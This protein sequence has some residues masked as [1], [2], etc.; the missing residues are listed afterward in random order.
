M[1]KILNDKK[2]TLTYSRLKEIYSDI[3]TNKT[4]FYNINENMTNVIIDI[5]GEIID[6]NDKDPPTIFD[7]ISELLYDLRDKYQEQLKTTIPIQPTYQSTLNQ[8]LDNKI[9]N[10]QHTSNRPYEDQTQ[11]II[12][13]IPI[14]VKNID[15]SK[16]KLYLDTATAIKLSNPKLTKDIINQEI[17]IL[18][19]NL[20]NVKDY[21]DI[22]KTWISIAEFNRKLEQIDTYNDLTNKLKKNLEY[23]FDYESNYEPT[24]INSIITHQQY[25]SNLQ[26][27][28]K[29]GGSTD[30]TCTNTNYNDYSISLNTC[31]YDKFSQLNI[32]LYPK[33]ISI[34]LNPEVFCEM[35][36]KSVQTS[37]P[38][39]HPYNIVNK[40]LNTFFIKSY[41]RISTKLNKTFYN[42]RETIFDRDTEL[43]KSLRIQNLMIFRDK[44]EKK[45]DFEVKVVFNYIM[46]EINKIKNDKNKYI[47]N[48]K[49]L[50]ELQTYLLQN[51][52]YI[53]KS[54]LNNYGISD[55]SFETVLEF[56]YYKDQLYKS[57]ENLKIITENFKN[58]NPFIELTSPLNIK[59]TNIIETTY[60]ELMSKF[61][62]VLT[63]VKE[64]NDGYM[65]GLKGQL[66]PRYKINLSYNKLTEASGVI[67]NEN[68]IV[69]RD[70]PIKIGDPEIKYYDFEIEY[71]NYP[72]VIGL[73]NSGDNYYTPN[74]NNKY[75]FNM[76]QSLKDIS[77][78]KSKT[79]LINNKWEKYNL[80]KINRYY[81]SEVTSEQIAED[82]ECG[83]I[84]LQKLRNFENI[85]IIG[86]GQ[87]GA[88]KTAS[89]I[90][91]TTNGVNYPGLL[92]SIANKLIK[93]TT[94]FDDKTQ[95]FE[96]AYVQLINLYLKL[97]DNLDDINKMKPEHYLPYNIKLF[98]TNVDGIPEVDSNGNKIEIDVPGYYF[99]PKDGK[100]WCVRKDDV[101]KSQTPNND[102]KENTHSKIG[103]K[104]LDQIIAE[105]FEIREEE[106]TKNNPNSSRSH[107]VV[108]VTFTGKTKNAGGN[109]V[110]KQ[111]RVVI[112]DLAGVEDKF[113]CDLSELMIL[114]RNYS[115]KSNKYKTLDENGKAF[116]QE[117]RRKLRLKP[118]QFDDYYCTDPKYNTSDIFPQKILIKKRE[119][120]DKI[121]FFMDNYD[122]LKSGKDPVKNKIAL[123]I[124]KFE[125]MPIKDKD[126]TNFMISLSDYLK[127]LSEEIKENV[128]TNVT[129][130]QYTYTKDYLGNLADT[131]NN[132]QF[133]NRDDLEL[134]L[135]FITETNKQC[136]SFK[137]CCNN[138][139]QEKTKKISQFMSDFTKLPDG[140]H[141]D[142]IHP[143][144]IKTQDYV[145]GNFESNYK[146]MNNDEVK[147]KII[148]EI[149]KIVGGDVNFFNLESTPQFNFNQ[150]DEEITSITNIYT[151]NVKGAE[152]ACN[153]ETASG[154]INE[155]N[156]QSNL[157][158]KIQDINNEIKPLED[159]LKDYNNK[160]TNKTNE[161]IKNLY[162]FKY[163]QDKNKQSHIDKSLEKIPDENTA[164][165]I[166]TYLNNEGTVL[167]AKDNKTFILTFK[168]SIKDTLKKLFV[169]NKLKELLSL[170]DLQ[171][172]IDNLQT[173]IDTN[174]DK[175]NGL[176]KFRDNLTINEIKNKLDKQSETKKN[177]TIEQAKQD[178]IV[179]LSEICKKI[180][181]EYYIN[182]I[183]YRH[184][185]GAKKIRDYLLDKTKRAKDIEKVRYLIQQLIRFSQLE[186]NCKIR[187]KEG[188]MINTS[189]KEMQK[190]IGSILFESSKRR[191]NKV[192]IE[193]NLLKLPEEIYRYNDY[194]K[195]NNEISLII[196]NLLNTMNTLIITDNPQEIERNI[197][198]LKDLCTKVK[199]KV[200]H[201]F[202]YIIGIING[203]EDNYLPQINI[204]AI[205]LHICF[206]HT[207]I[208][209][210]TNDGINFDLIKNALK[211]MGTEKYTQLY[212]EIVKNNITIQDN[213][214]YSSNATFIK[215]KN[216]FTN[217]YG[218]NNNNN[219]KDFHL[220]HAFYE[221]SEK[222]NPE[223]IN[224][225]DFMQL[226]HKL[227][228]NTFDKTNQNNNNNKYNEGLIINNELMIKSV[229]FDYLYKELVGLWKVLN[230]YTTNNIKAFE[231][232]V[233]ET[234]TDN[235]LHPSPLL[236]SSPSIDSCVL[237]K[238]KY[239]DEYDKFYNFEKNNSPLEYLF[240]IMTTSSTNS[241]IKGV[242]G[243]GLEIENST[244]VIFTVINVT[245]N[246]TA[247]TN[248]PPTPPF[249]NINKLKL[250]YKILSIPETG[251]K[252][253]LS[254]LK[255]NNKYNIISQIQ[256]I[257][258]HYYDKIMEYPFYKSFESKFSFLQN[259]DELTDNKGKRLKEDVIDF[260]DSNNATT[261][262][263]T[264]DFEKF[265]K[266]R[267]PT[268][269]YYI[270]DNKNESLLKQIVVQEK[271]NQLLTESICDLNINN[272][273]C[274]DKQHPES[275]N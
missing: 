157:D 143:D 176:I 261:L 188:Y 198:I 105:A 169:D 37:N 145:Y 138:D 217:L 115:T 75:N 123:N 12:N 195:Y 15:P 141:P 180:Q 229:S 220:L 192:L 175:I 124:Q 223:N 59:Y 130:Y 84:L 103:N 250:I 202:M 194:I 18:Y 179:N 266:I 98:N 72:H 167:S 270:C 4:I 97:D 102:D 92:P 236:Y 274:N 132:E 42:G 173:K 256:D 134:N 47:F 125:E 242:N 155:K 252:T 207:I 77:N 73:T 208:T 215:L 172:E 86:N 243:F 153:Q 139:T 11:K 199:R 35:W 275:K 61:A 265:T 162:I 189:L 36:Y 24:D 232:K 216:I 65:Y 237:K 200:L 8:T 71:F 29:V 253:V 137:D 67:S 168:K 181:I 43:F 116:S 209:L 245:P 226:I 60:I 70:K 126:N 13:Q 45:D 214:M 49:L 204:C 7:V 74:K 224:I 210:L 164:K 31:F 131:T 88:G 32:D 235:K 129:P 227:F 54:K 85:I 9:I 239:D 69:Y 104:T 154:G 136:N 222:A 161:N 225:N 6:I 244:L 218:E 28:P 19:S 203:N 58:G 184:T 170:D 119:L 201:Y 197:K 66:N 117:E 87:S 107:I 120:M 14:E 263:G 95:Y 144:D 101:V 191:F 187:R 158:K 259:I 159:E 211:N 262:L 82:A 190:F 150:Y 57:L 257:G 90:S 48:Y 78:I 264:V 89:L 51:N 113:T 205:L 25:I 254:L 247:P 149:Q 68:E 248:N 118:I 269:P 114:D 221:Y 55:T 46:K 79:D 273:N 40:L 96:T 64:R 240:K 246:P 33:L 186:F 20:S 219:K 38:I 99:M 94:K 165:T 251:S 122:K 234:T 106:P 93:P 228:D 135:E 177:Q 128:I 231:V 271:I 63:Y 230:E 183:K 16:R 81:G 53:N 146:D 91:R 151:N 267:D 112:C 156:A 147:D 255:E 260:I 5:L 272:S 52:E 3:T 193:N 206:I 111:S 1:S 185:E 182:L 83:M 249:I 171:T 133:S 178:Y 160:K 109:D 174:N 56:L 21:H 163:L 10:E 62:Q 268:Q 80:G 241:I 233:K 39:T 238:N 76:N 50:N 212:E 142:A 22:K 127:N 148:N 17:G 30:S 34:M 41:T 213:P 110:D 26:N 108:C 27:K 121:I 196:N 152:Y 100:W 140:T 23:N 258:K 166:N 44:Y 2:Y